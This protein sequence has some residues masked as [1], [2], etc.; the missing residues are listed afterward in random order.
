MIKAVNQLCC[1]YLWNGISDSF[2]GAKVAWKSVCQPT[3]EGGLG[4]KNLAIWNRAHAA[5]QLLFSSS[6][7][8]WIAW[9][10][11]I[12]LKR[13]SFWLINPSPT[14]SW[15]WKRLLSLRQCLHPLLKFTIGNGK[16]ILLWWITGTQRGLCILSTPKYLLCFWAPTGL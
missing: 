9:M 7:S 3:T 5:R 10:H 12:L 11:S 14:S 4:L 15:N 16:S 8:L 2:V 6:G 13:K 1:S